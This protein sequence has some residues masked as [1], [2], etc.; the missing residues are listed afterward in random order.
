MS[1]AVFYE[2][3]SGTQED[4]QVSGF[5]CEEILILISHRLQKNI[6]RS[7]K[8]FLAGKKSLC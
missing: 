4:D 5:K 6:K 2:K 3:L 1:A 7:K 8:S